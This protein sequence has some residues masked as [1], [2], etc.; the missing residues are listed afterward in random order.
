MRLWWLLLGSALTAGAA[1][2]AATPP[3]AA[4]TPFTVED[5]VVLK[6]LSDP[7]PSPD[8]RF[9]AFVQRDTDVGANKTH[10]SLWLL[11]LGSPGAQPR[12]LT[13]AAGSDSSPRW[14]SDSRTLFFLSARSGS[15]QVWRLSLAAATA[16]RLT[17]YPLD[18][19]AL[20]VSPRD[21][22]LAISME[23][24][25]DCATLDCTRAR[26]DARASGQASGRVYERLFVRH[27]DTWSNGTR[28]HLFT[29]RVAASGFAGAPVDVSRGF[30]ADIPGKPFGGDEDFAFSPTAV[31][32]CSRPASP[33]RA[34]R[35][36]PTSTCTRC[37]WT[38][39]LQR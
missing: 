14:A 35:G 21:D 9:L 32:W 23:V 6:R 2:A 27:W 25:P 5:M 31:P 24:F 7:R 15:S 1:A 4:G 29:A 3:A 19:G 10:T 38:A 11:D 36:Q 37:R 33:G 17:D 30:D 16:Q 13:D 34:S 28:S 12:R 18:V 8:G 22:V 26:L 20:A 39:A